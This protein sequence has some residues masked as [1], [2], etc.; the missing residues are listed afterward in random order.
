M[1]SG[2]IVLASAGF[3]GSIAPAAAART[4][5][6]TTPALAAAH[7]Q[8]DAIERTI[9]SLQ[10]RVHRLEAARDRL[11]GRLT[12]PGALNPVSAPELYVTVARE[13]PRLAE[14]LV[15]TREALMHLDRRRRQVAERIER[16]R[17]RFFREWERR[18]EERAREAE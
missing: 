3:G 12:L 7:R 13:L 11:A 17:A 18:R 14:V 4:P 10:S 5:A 8:H 6:G 15:R 16:L 1:G 2:L 9:A